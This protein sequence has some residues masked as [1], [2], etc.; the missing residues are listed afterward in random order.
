[1]D[2]DGA[3]GRAAQMVVGE[4]YYEAL[5]EYL[6]VFEAAS[7]DE[8]G[9]CGIALS[10]IMLDKQIDVMTVMGMAIA[11]RLDAGWPHG[12][13]G[14]I[15]QEQNSPDQA[16]ECYDRMIRFDPSDASAYVRKAQILLEKGR[17]KECTETVAECAR[18]AR[19]D[20]E[21][22]RAVERL[23]EL[24]DDIDAGRLPKFES[25]DEGVFMPGLRDLLDRAIGNDI[26]YWGSNT[27]ATSLAGSD[28]RARAVDR[29]NKMIRLQPDSAENWCEKGVLL[30][31]GGLADQ[32]RVCYERAID[33][34]PGMM[35]PYAEK[36]TLFQDAGDLAGMKECLRAAIEAKPD[37]A[38]NAEMQKGL[39]AWFNAMDRSANKL[40][41]VHNAE[42]V[43]KHIARRLVPG[44]GAPPALPQT[45]APPPDMPEGT[46]FP[47]SMLDRLA[48]CGKAGK[49]RR[50]RLRSGRR[51]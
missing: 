30:A 26:P 32:A 23:R 15:M 19:L 28:E 4:M 17:E 20:K 1:M 29:A 33:M 18:V 24:F 47:P 27:Y 34:R 41:S 21:P 8:R 48:P 14:A 16:V 10:L 49:P 40:R 43:R 35:V 3:I 25:K 38:I 2:I 6:A 7:D 39:R 44:S 37:D 13:L 50:A 31:E 9:Y 51:R 42:A 36:A 5:R 46:L 45:H 22:P 12:V 11:N